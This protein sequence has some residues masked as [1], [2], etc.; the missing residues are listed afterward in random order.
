MWSKKNLIRK[1]PVLVHDEAKKGKK[2]VITHKKIN[3]LKIKSIAWIIH[4]EID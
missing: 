1:L 2:K 3:I 4:M